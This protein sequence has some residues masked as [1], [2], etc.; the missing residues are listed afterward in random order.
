MPRSLVLS[1]VAMLVLGFERAQESPPAASDIEV[2]WKASHAAFAE[3]LAALARWAMEKDLYREAGYLVRE[4]LLVLPEHA[5]GEIGAEIRKLSADDFSRGY[6]DALRKSGR[7]FARR[8]TALAQPFAKSAVALAGEAEKAGQSAFAESVLLA[9]L[10]ADPDC[11]AAAKELRKR[12]YDVIFNYGAVPK[13]DK[14]AARRA[15]KQLGGGFLTRRDLDDVLDFWSDAWGL[16]TEHYKVITNAPHRTVFQFAQ[17]CEDLFG[18]WEQVMREGGI[19]LRPPK[20]RFEVWFFDSPVTFEA[21]LRANRM[22]PPKE[23]LGFYSGESKT[24]YF[25]DWPEFYVGDLTLLLETLYHEGTHQLCDLR[26]KATDRGTLAKFPLAWMQ[27]GFALYME[28]LEVPADTD[29]KKRS[30]V[31]GE[32]VDDDL[33]GALAESE[34]FL[35]FE[36]FV[37]IAPDELANYEYH[38][39]HAALVTHFLLHGE[40][41]AWRKKGIGLLEKVYE[42]G[43]IKVSLAD[44]LKVDQEDFEAA[45][46]EHIAMIAKDLRRRTYRE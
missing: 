39:P 10:R 21:L 37:H 16:D 2:R 42:S 28:L 1:F 13:S 19:K 15:L 34:A 32:F 44:Y 46:A 8:E 43:G 27:E 29:D 22:D 5:V 35:P 11:D 17:A 23:V 24:G 33:G 36:E 38:Y 12:D 31:L 30:F 41:G 14:E 7:E 40:G 3:E 6:E 20:D 18:A 25:F 4:V 45:F 26:M 9:A